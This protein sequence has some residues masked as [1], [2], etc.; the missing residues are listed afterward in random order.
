MNGEANSPAEAESTKA[1]SDVSKDTPT[2][3]VKEIEVEKEA[4]KT[5]E[6]FA[7]FI[8]SSPE[9]RYLN[10]LKT[11]PNLLQSVPQHQIASFL[12]IKPESLS[13]LKKRIL[14]KTKS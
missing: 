12:G 2:E 1:K 10:L 14:I 7:L 6:N 3:E 5:Q 9:E 13:R 4:G 8:T 11:R